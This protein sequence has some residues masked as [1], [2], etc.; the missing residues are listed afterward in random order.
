MDIT[1]YGDQP[2]GQ[3]FLKKR[4]EGWLISIWR[5]IKWDLLLWKKEFSAWKRKADQGPDESIRVH[6]F[7]KT[8]R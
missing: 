3:A 6:A 8:V 5:L 7:S 4:I 1:G 2:A